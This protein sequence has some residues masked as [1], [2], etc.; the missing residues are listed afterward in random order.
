[1]YKMRERIKFFYTPFEWRVFKRRRAS[2]G[3]RRQPQSPAMAMRQMR[4]VIHKFKPSVDWVLLKR[5]R[6][7]VAFGV[8]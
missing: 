7:S 1:M 3:K 6:A 5:R 2:M 4:Y 8:K